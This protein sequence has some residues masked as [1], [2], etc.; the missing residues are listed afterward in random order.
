MPQGFSIAGRPIGFGHPPYV[1][2]EISANHAQD[3]AVALRIVRECADAGVDA[4]KIQTYRAE[5]MTI[6]TDL[7][8]FQIND[9]PWAG[10]RLFELYRRAEMPWEWTLPLKDLAEQLGMVL[11]S[12]PFDETAVDFLESCDVPAYKV[13]SF[14][15]T[16]L[17][18]LR[19]VART[20]KPVIVSTGLASKVEVSEALATLAEFGASQVAVLKCTSS[21]PADMS[22]LNLALIPQMKL[23]FGV[24]VGYSDHTIGT[25]AAVAAVAMGACI[26]EKHVQTDGSESSPD[27]AFSMTASDMGAYVR[28]ARVAALAVGEAAYGP[29]PSEV[30]SLAFRRSLMAATD[31]Q[32]GHI[33]GPDDVVVRRPAGGLPPAALERVIGSVTTRD[34]RR[35]DFV[36]AADV[37]AQLQF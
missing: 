27:A 6:D 10:E 18:L 16:D 29:T 20:R 30:P 33:V 8:A 31:M 4:I 13:A 37:D 22:D 21:Y 35:G 5:T 2:A 19:R 7:P 26:L 1:I 34:L 17:P 24:P 36:T 28:A 15:I 14:E 3:L 11:F 25:V 12:S 9:G 32:V 23:D